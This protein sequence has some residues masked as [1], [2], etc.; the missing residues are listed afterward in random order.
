MVT[1]RT[2]LATRAAARSQSALECHSGGATNQ[3]RWRQ[4]RQISRAVLK[5]GDFQKS[6]WW[7]WREKGEGGEREGRGR[8]RV[9]IHVA[10]RFNK[11]GTIMLSPNKSVE[12][13][14]PRLITIGLCMRRL[15]LQTLNCQLHTYKHQPDQT[16]S[17]LENGVGLSISEPL[18]VEVV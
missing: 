3:C 17:K 6:L 11:I 7:A 2:T 8:F 1:R 14:S 9:L 5:S 15:A 4:L 18:C 13:D 12:S 10:M 16:T